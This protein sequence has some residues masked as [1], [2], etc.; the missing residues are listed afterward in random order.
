MQFL[1]AYNNSTKRTPISV[2]LGSS[3]HLRQKWNKQS[4]T[5]QTLSMLL[6]YLK[7]TQTLTRQ[8]IN[9]ENRVYYQSRWRWAHHCWC[10]PCR[11]ADEMCRM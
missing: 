5:L 6:L 7:M 3:T 9:T 4:T 2:I 1:F 11:S 10:M 8:D